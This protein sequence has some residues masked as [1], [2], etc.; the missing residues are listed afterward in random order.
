MAD[1]E[2]CAAGCANANFDRE[3]RDGEVYV[4]LAGCIRYPRLFGSP[5]ARFCLDLEQPVDG[6]SIGAIDE[7]VDAISQ[8]D[9]TLCYWCDH[10]SPRQT[11]TAVL[12]SSSGS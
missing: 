12:L 4:V 6:D 7:G 5:M 10:Y 1:K 9:Q 11:E 3:E 2:K 8:R